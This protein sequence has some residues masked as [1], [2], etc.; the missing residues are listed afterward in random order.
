[1]I[2]T[3]DT[4]LLALGQHEGIGITHPRELKNIFAVDVKPTYF[5]PE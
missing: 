4:D 2:V 5:S 1:L 3:A